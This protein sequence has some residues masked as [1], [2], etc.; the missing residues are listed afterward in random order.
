MGKLLKNKMSEIKKY[1]DDHIGKIIYVNE[2]ANIFKIDKN[3]L[4]EQFKMIYNQSP[5]EYIIEKKIEKLC[6][7]LRESDDGKICYYYAYELG[8]ETSSGLCNLIKRKTGLTFK[9]F[10]DQILNSE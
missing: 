3:N 9:E 6:Q 10:K 1:I 2:I 7:I 5:K 4:D 8:F